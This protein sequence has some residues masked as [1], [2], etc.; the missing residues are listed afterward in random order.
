[1]PSAD[2]RRI[3]I[4]THYLAA[5]LVS[6]LESSSA[7]ARITSGPDG[8]MIE[9]GEGNVHPL[10][11]TMIDI[12]R[13]LE[14]ME[15]QAIDFALLS[16]N[17]PGVDWFE[18]DAGI[19]VAR[20]VNDELVALVARHPQRLQALATLPMQAPED[21]A[22]ELERAVGLGLPG[23]M[24]YSNAAGR[25]LDGEEYEVVFAT[26]A[27]L[28]APIMIHPTY[29]LS[30]RLVDAYALIPTIGFLFDTSTAALRLILGGLY[31]RHPD[32]KLILCHTGS[33]LP[34]IAGRIDYEASRDPNGLGA[35]SVTPS[36]HIR[37][38]YTD[39]VCVWPPAIRAALELFGVDHMMFGTDYP[40]WEPRRT[41]DTLEA[42]GLS[43]AETEAIDR[44]TAE[45]LF[46]FGSRIKD[47]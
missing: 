17:V 24:V 20:E 45:R 3:D 38:L 28:D 9:Y 43:G 36:E 31:E 42:A 10:L 8:R 14:E 11:P 32:I 25:A 27:R 22:A 29:P 30:A 47:A 6:A 23:A 1:M 7:R 39:T 18:P 37:R 21:A 15:E 26:A 34:Q 5:A 35:I 4:H 13:Q 19:A 44:G 12:D 33:L 40:F 41:I 46:S 2:V 16:V